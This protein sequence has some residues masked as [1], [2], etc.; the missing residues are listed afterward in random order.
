MQRSKARQAG[1]G[2]R[3]A[4]PTDELMGLTPTGR[5]LWM[6]SNAAILGSRLR[7]A[8]VEAT[9]RVE[10]VRS[11]AQSGLP[12]RR[13]YLRSRATVIAE[14]EF[15]RDWLWLA[16][17]QLAAGEP[18]LPVEKDWVMTRTCLRRIR[19][20]APYLASWI[21]PQPLR[22][23]ATPM[24]PDQREQSLFENYL[25]A[26]E[27]ASIFH[28]SHALRLSG[29]SVCL[30]LVAIYASGPWLI[31]SAIMMLVALTAIVLRPDWH[32]ANAATLFNALAIDL[33]D[34]EGS[35]TW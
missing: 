34:N 2:N 23:A 4:M 11:I 26:R 5:C 17:G 33:Q 14:W 21:E 3:P 15:Y 12:G 16:H 27:R 32:A 20:W 31:V 1:P 29:W 25:Q 8:L 13:I 7:H 9:L 18:G 22:G 28:P 19:P 30:A 6:D 35:P 10:E 24:T